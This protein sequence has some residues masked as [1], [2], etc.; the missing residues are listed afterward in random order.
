M[1]C[2]TVDSGC[3]HELMNNAF[4]ST[5]EGDDASEQPGAVWLV[6]GAFDHEFSRM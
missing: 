2:G 5:E 1:D 3:N 6:L 4:A